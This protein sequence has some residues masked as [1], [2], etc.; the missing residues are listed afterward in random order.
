[1]FLSISFLFFN[2]A[3]HDIRQAIIRMGRWDVKCSKGFGRKAL[4][5]QIPRSV[6]REELQNEEEEGFKK[7]LEC[8]CNM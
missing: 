7:Y 8:Y 6:G 3:D 4:F 1:M 5:I 2:R